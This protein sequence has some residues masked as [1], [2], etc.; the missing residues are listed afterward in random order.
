MRCTSDMWTAAVTIITPFHVV[1][2]MGLSCYISFRLWFGLCDNGFLWWVKVVFIYNIW[3][4]CLTVPAY[5]CAFVCACVCMICTSVRVCVLT[6]IRM[7]PSS[8]SIRMSASL[9]FSCRRLICTSRRLMSSAAVVCAKKPV[10]T[11]LVVE[12]VCCD[13]HACIQ[14]KH[15]MMK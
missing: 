15:V 4:W 12:L 13:I 6:W 10:T 1:W 11:T 14:N 3:K 9:S 7:V 5:M 2:C 8:C